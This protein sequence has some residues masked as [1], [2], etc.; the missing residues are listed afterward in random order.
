MFRV[1]SFAVNVA[2]TSLDPRQLVAWTP[3]SRYG[4]HA[5]GF[6]NP[7]DIASRDKSFAAFAAH[8]AELLPLIGEYSPYA[9]ASEDDPPVY[10]F[11]PTPP[12]LGKPQQDPTHTANYGVMLQ[13]HCQRLGVACELVYPGAP[14]IQHASI[15]NY[16]ISTLKGPAPLLRSSPRVVHEPSLAL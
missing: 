4:G 9:L 5:F 7:R 15:D 2:Q 1:M 6:M 8:R 11:Y 12:A 10:L 14:D 3:N 16:L 13:R